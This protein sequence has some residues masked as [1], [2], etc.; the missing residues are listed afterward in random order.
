[1]AFSDANHRRPRELLHRANSLVVSDLNV[2]SRHG[3][4]VVESLEA[5]G[6]EPVVATLAPGEDHKTLSDLLPAYER[7]LSARIERG[8]HPNT[9]GGYLLSRCM[10][11]GIKQEVPDL[12]KYLVDDAG[13]FDPRHPEPMPDDF[14]LPPDPRPA[15]RGG[16]RG[17][18]AATKPAG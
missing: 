4:I 12:A 9:Y 8:T 7:I 16:R 11:E 3:R 17:G 13:T 1:M 18:P 6:I 5:A 2:F 14:K 15:G 10:V